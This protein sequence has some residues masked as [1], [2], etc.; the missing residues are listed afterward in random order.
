[1]QNHAPKDRH[2]LNFKAVHHSHQHTPVDAKRAPGQK[3]GQVAKPDVVLPPAGD[4]GDTA[5]DGAAAAAPLP[6]VPPA[7]A[8]RKRPSKL[9]S[10]KIGASSHVD[11]APLRS[12]EVQ[13]RIATLTKTP[14]GGRTAA[15]TSPA[16]APLPAAMP[17]MDK[18]HRNLQAPHADQHS[19][20]I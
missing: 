6:P 13:P 19:S 17:K 2:H 16:G 20:S 3:D 10:T 14:G 7:K 15:P 1:M 9:P 8:R 4:T 18:E 11:G 5:G 12:L